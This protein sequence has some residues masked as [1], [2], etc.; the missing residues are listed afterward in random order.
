ML[1]NRQLVEEMTVALG[2]AV[3]SCWSSIPQDVQQMLFE[4][5]AARHGQDVRGALAL[6][7]HEHNPRT[8][9]AGR[10]TDD[11]EPQLFP[12]ERIAAN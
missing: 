7:L 2:A 12:P 4:S 5:A 3:L 8:A 10:A 9:D 11:E 6:F 1:E